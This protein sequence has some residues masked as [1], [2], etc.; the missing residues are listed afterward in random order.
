MKQESVDTA[1]ISVL[2]G[3]V[4]IIPNLHLFGS[5]SN[6][7]F[8]FIYGTHTSLRFPFP[9]FLLERPDTEIIITVPGCITV[10]PLYVSSLPISAVCTL[11]G[12]SPQQG[13]SNIILFLYFIVSH[14]STH[15]QS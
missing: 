9:L 11:Q 7:S 5:D 4:Y 1:T 6:F 13:H 14:Y 15:V 12:I 10:I 2:S 3:T 8:L